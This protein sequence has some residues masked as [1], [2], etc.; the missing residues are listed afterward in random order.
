MGF[1]VNVVAKN[2]CAEQI[3]Q[4][5]QKKFNTFLVYT[6][7]IIQNEI[8]F[9]QKSDDRKHLQYITS[10]EQWNK[11]FPIFKENCG[12]IFLRAYGY[13]DEESAEFQKENQLLKEQIL[14]L[15]ELRFLFKEIKN[16][17]DAND[18]FDDLNIDFDAIIN[19]KKIHYEEPSFLN[20]PQPRNNKVYDK[21]L[22]LN[23]PKL[24]SLYLAYKKT[25]SYDVWKEMRNLIIDYNI[26]FGETL[27]QRVE[28]LY[29]ARNNTT[30]SIYNPHY[31]DKDKNVPPE[32]VMR[33][34][35]LID[36]MD[37]YLKNFN[38]AN[39]V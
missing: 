39:I 32:S 1:Y 29:S 16:L 3:N 34:A 24:W 36:N 28:K 17:N 20:L 31:N 35:I 9:I 6:P 13:S 4:L 21:C 12:Q 26:G 18:V 38:H 7:T 14:Y 5:W 15:L 27:W 11:T 25:Y 22:F 30:A 19:G 23:Q 8:D 10:I 33:L 37:E 2:E